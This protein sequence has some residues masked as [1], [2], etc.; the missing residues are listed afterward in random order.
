MIDL[1]TIIA[2]IESEK[3]LSKAAFQSI[4]FDAVLDSRDEEPFDS[5]WVT[6]HQR[7]E[8]AWSASSTD[9]QTAQVNK[10]RQAAFVAASLMTN[11]HEIA[12]YIS[13]DF[14]LIAKS[15]VLGDLD[16]FTSGLVKR[17]ERGGVPF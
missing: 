1:D 9:E 8:A 11:N 7:I 13:D 16:S 14:E 6:S 3:L 10:I 5:N 15:V 4:D 2:E 12:A 17:Y